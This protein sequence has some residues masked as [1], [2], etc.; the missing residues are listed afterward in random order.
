MTEVVD[1][2]LGAKSGTREGQRRRKQYTEE[3]QRQIS[4]RNIIKDRR[5]GCDATTAEGVGVVWG[6]RL[7]SSNQVF[8]VGTAG[9]EA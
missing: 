2:I 6:R 8:S 4:K 3:S 1:L 5:R 7:R 9:F